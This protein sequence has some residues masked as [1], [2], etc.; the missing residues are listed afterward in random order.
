ML[1][2]RER[3]GEHG[4]IGEDQIKLHCSGGEEE[5]KREMRRDLMPFNIIGTL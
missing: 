4:F 5:E 1:D 3:G 2:A